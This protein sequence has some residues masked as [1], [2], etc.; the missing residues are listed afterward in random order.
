MGVGMTDHFRRFDSRLLPFRSTNT[1]H[2]HFVIVS[3]VFGSCFQTSFHPNWMVYCL[4]FK[5][6]SD[7]WPS[8]LEWAHLLISVCS[9]TI[10]IN[11]RQSHFSCRFLT[12]T[13]RFDAFFSLFRTGD[14][15]NKPP[16]RHNG[17]RLI[18]FLGSICHSI[19]S[20]QHFP[21]ASNAFAHFD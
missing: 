5:S 15:S 13:T 4:D 17:I 8:P 16:M 9:R 14:A 7:H 3:I 21:I 19:P 12:F 18:W 2:T 6:M 20:Y 11:W 1:R 10:W